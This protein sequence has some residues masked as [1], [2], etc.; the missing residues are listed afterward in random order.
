LLQGGGGNDTYTIDHVGVTVIEGIGEGTDLV[1]SSITYAIEQYVE[2]LTLTGTAAINR[3]DGGLGAD[4]LIGGPATMC[5]RWTI[6]AMWWWKRPRAGP[7][8]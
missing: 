5:M 8:I 2:N 6:Q 3:L 1:N 7:P 4:L